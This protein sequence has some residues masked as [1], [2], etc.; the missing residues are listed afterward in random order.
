M[1]INAHM[2]SDFFVVFRNDLVSSRKVSPEIKKQFGGNGYTLSLYSGDG[3]TR[4]SK[5]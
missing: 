3:L 5:T 4:M 1:E 2:N